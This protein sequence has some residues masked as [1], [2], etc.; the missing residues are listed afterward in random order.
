MPSNA[1]ETIDARIL[2]LIGLEDIFDLDYDTYI[3][4]LKE[5]M[6]KGR[7]PKTTIPSEEV[8]L[9]TDE[10]KRVKT[11]K[12]KG[13]FKV[14][15]TKITA[16]AL[17][18]G[19]GGIL[20][21][22]KTSIPISR[23]LPAAQT[24]SDS[25]GFNLSE[26]F[27]KIAESVTSIAKTLKE[28][29]LLSKKEAAFDKR[30]DE[31][32]RRKLQ[33]ENLKKSFAKMAAVAQKILQPVQSL[34]DKIINYFT[35]IFLGRVVIKLLNWF[36]KD[37]NQKKVKSFVRFIGDWWPALV[38]GWL[39]FGT[40]IGGL[41]ANLVPMVVG[42]T[43]KLAAVIAKHP[44]LAAALAGAFATTK[45][46][47]DSKKSA[48]NVLDEKGLANASN[49]EQSAALMSPS[50]LLSTFTGTINPE[51]RGEDKVEDKVE[52][53]PV[54]K[55]FGFIPQPKPGSLVSEYN[56]GGVVDTDAGYMVPGSGSG[57]TVDAKLTP[58]EFV[59]N[60]PTV[61]AIGVD[62]LLEQN[63]LYGGPNANKPRMIGST[64]F[65]NRG[66]MVGRKSSS[67]P[68]KMASMRMLKAYEG[69]GKHG[70][71]KPYLDTENIPTIGYGATLMPTW[72]TGEN[73][74]RPVRM[75]DRITADQADK[76]KEY[77]YDRHRDIVERELKLVGV[78]LQH[79]V[80]INVGAALMSLAFNYG[81]LTG[82]HA[83]T[84]S[85]H[86]PNGKM[87][88]PNP[89]PIMVQIAQ[90]SGDWSEISNLLRYNLSKDNNGDLRQRR[91]SEANIID[92]GSGTGYHGLQDLSTSKMVNKSGNKGIIESL[93][94]TTGLSG[95][96][97]SGIRN[98]IPQF[99]KGG[100]V[101]MKVGQN[102]T[103][104]KPVSPPSSNLSMEDDFAAAVEAMTSLGDSS[105]D[106]GSTAYSNVP[107]IPLPGGYD[108]KLS[109]LGLR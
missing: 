59:V 49:K 79:H 80:P 50:G 11:K 12:D 6:V 101:P 89:L 21:G 86:G 2:R 55:I 105:L 58:G 72:I 91:L 46:I 61:D 108:I 1:T 63:R 4:L 67:D 78:S 23:L 30:A 71:T 54:G 35:M 81:S 83:G 95:M 9:L 42:W 66:G 88:F 18:T 56:N 24:G 26:S 76:L 102:R 40:G 97:P 44:L 82:A 20:I 98:M 84:S 17:K 27:A 103:M 13:R 69:V 87:T 64:M 100:E 75:T 106:I 38:G 51:A 32:E 47:L 93:K 90:Q 5:A 70:I 65:A 31:N 57:D 10:W 28:K 22:K 16:A 62:Y 99:H 73:K 77:D 37:E 33:K 45:L 3:T 92:T 48:E 68:M 8:E 85:R 104:I 7:M 14:K 107:S 36:S 34:L 43:V 109:V 19:G 25:G 60:K 29:F 39:L 94:D 53:K 52:D 41:I 74:S 15:K 96:I